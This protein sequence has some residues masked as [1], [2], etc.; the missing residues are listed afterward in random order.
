MV[1]LK[2]NKTDKDLLKR[3]FKYVLKTDSCWYWWGAVNTSRKRGRRYGLFFYE[4]KPEYA[5]RISYCLHKGEILA[6]QQI[7]H[8]CDNPFCVNPAHLSIG[9]AQDN[10]NDAKDKGRIKKWEN[11]GRAKLTNQQIEEIFSLDGLVTRKAIAAKYNVSATNISSILNGKTWKG[12][13]G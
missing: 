6:G 4:G 8:S 11:H 10:S 1:R 2:V 9:T 13:R 7:M 5:H 12:L 3:F